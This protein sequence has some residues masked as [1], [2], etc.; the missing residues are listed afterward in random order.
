MIRVVIAD[1]QALV[2]TGFRM[3]LDGTDDMTVVGE[4]ADGLQALAVAGE[5]SPDVV[6][7]DVRMPVM[8]GVEATRRIREARPDACVLMLTGSNAAADVD[9]SRDAGAAGYS[10]GLCAEVMTRIRT[11]LDRFTGAEFA[12][13][14]NHGYFSCEDG[15]AAGQGSAATAHRHAA[16]DWPFPGFAAEAEVRSALQGSHRRFLHARWWQ[17]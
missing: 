17:N 12:I 3:I 5:T 16:L 2:R 13:L 7:M 9:R 11:D 14:V 1:D 4:A 15:L 10:A 8:D 6:L